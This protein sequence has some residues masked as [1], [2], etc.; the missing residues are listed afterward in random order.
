MLSESPHVY[1]L[2]ITKDVCP[3]TFVRT[4][5]AIERLEPGGILDV[6]VSGTEPLRT[7]PPGMEELGHRIIAIEAE[8]DAPVGAEPAIHHIRIV[9][10]C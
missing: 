4:K 6:R 5:L 8:V 1:F 3:L 10:A 2:D 7:I 9:K